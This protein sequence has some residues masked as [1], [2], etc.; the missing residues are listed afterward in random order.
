MNADHTELENRLRAAYVAQTSVITP[1]RLTAR[2]A[3]TG[4]DAAPMPAIGTLR[5]PNLMLPLLAAAAVIAIATAAVVVKVSL[6]GH[7][8]A[9]P[10]SPKPTHSS[11]SLLPRGAQGTRA[12]IPWDQVGPGWTL[13]DWSPNPQDTAD[14]VPSTVFLV[15]PVG[16][17]YEITTLPAGD[18]IEQWSPNHRKMLLAHSVFDLATGTS[19]SLHLP[20]NVNL[21]GFTGDS[22]GFIG[23]I[24]QTDG[25]GAIVSEQ[26]ARFDLT[27]RKLNTYPSTLPGMGKLVVSDPPPLNT[28]DGKQLIVGAQNGLVFF[29]LN[30]TVA[31]TAAPIDS[32]G[33]T[34]SCQPDSFWSSTVLLAVCAENGTK[35]T[36]A[37]WK[38]PLDGGAPTQFTGYA[39]GNYFAFLDAWP[40]STGVVGLSAAGC[41]P[42]YL[43]RFDQNMKPMPFS[44]SRPDGASK[45]GGQRYI[46]HDGDSITMMFQSGGCQSSVNTLGRVD[47]VTGT[48]V[49]LLGPGM[50]GGN[51][52]EA[53]S[54]ETEILF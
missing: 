32:S 1:E 45:T 12:D 34:V 18:S 11:Q 43:I 8:K 40:T 30:G 46:A 50:N 9:Q 7:H 35:N 16:G 13:A 4:T 27:G 49:A 17:R 15:N 54:P 42:P 47:A 51:V 10:A 28:P 39:T 24:D 41:G 33:R 52:V 22:A 44:N 14:K 6:D 48:S 5:R 21:R 53:I 38:F 37:L 23:D 26:L 2:S 19:I 3:P 29:H 25:T 36:G 31:R 20:D